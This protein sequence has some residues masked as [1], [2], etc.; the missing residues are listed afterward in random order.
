MNND[1]E[2]PKQKFRNLREVEPNL[3]EVIEGDFE[4]FIA[5]LPNLGGDKM[6]LTEVTQIGFAGVMRFRIVDKSFMINSALKY[7]Q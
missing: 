2:S 1:V 6:W 4:D 3:F 5:Q 7:S